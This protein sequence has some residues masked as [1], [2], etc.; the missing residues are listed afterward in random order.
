MEQTDCKQTATNF[1]NSKLYHVSAVFSIYILPYKIVCIDDSMGLAV[2]NGN[3]KL[4]KNYH[5]H[6][7]GRASAFP[8]GPILKA[9]IHFEIVVFSTSL[10]IGLPKML[11]ISYA[12]EW[13]QLCT[14]LTAVASSRTCTIYTKYYPPVFPWPLNRFSPFQK[15][16]LQ[17]SCLIA[18][19]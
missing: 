12:L 7:Y 4:S 11:H 19:I 2:M 8:N 17:L 10:L 16:I 9:L 13:H 18:A 5:H 14:I 1:I 6:T 3:W 15:Q